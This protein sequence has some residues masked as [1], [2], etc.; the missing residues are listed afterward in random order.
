MKFDSVNSFVEYLQKNAETFS[1]EN[2]ERITKMA[3]AQNPIITLLTCSD[4]R[5]DMSFFDI[6]PINT[7]FTVR[8]I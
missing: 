7:V 5:V 8:N 4:S 3:C 6:D 2:S 1:K